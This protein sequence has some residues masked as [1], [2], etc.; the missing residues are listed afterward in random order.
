MHSLLPPTTC[1]AVVVAFGL[2]LFAVACSTR[3]PTFSGM[4]DAQVSGMVDA[5]VPPGAATLTI[6]HGGTATGTVSSNPGG[7]TC[8][9]T[10]SAAFVAGTMVVLTATPGTNSWFTGWSGGGCTGTGTCTVRMAVATTVTATFNP[11][12]ALTVMP[13]GD[14]TV[15][16]NP[17]GINCDAACTENYAQDARVI[18]T[19][20]ANM[21]STF[22]SWSGCT[23][24]NTNTCMAM[25]NQATTITATFKYTLTVSIGAGA[26]TGTIVST[27]NGGIYCGDDCTEDY[28]PDTSVTLSAGAASGSKFAEWSGPCT[29]TSGSTCVVTMTAA[30]SVSAHFDLS[31][32]PGGGGGG[33]IGANYCGV[34]ATPEPSVMAAFM[35][36]PP[37]GPRDR[38]VG[39]PT[40]P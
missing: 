18:L 1:F 31:I 32:G 38:S 10:C 25:M 6:T 5:Q 22:G 34:T 36:T 7:I 39:S 17:P 29:S 37:P 21:G 35:S 33:C 11:M 9:A 27:P 24:T 40:V 8:G 3:D 19:A 20:T 30:K 23:S 28:V 12:Y 26:G 14:G 16:L 2:S 13:I 4:D 15:A